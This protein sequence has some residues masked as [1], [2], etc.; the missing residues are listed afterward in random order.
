MSKYK[1]TFKMQII[2][3]N[4][5]AGPGDIWLKHE[6]ALPFPPTDNFGYTDGNW[7]I[8]NPRWLEEPFGVKL[9]Y[10]DDGRTLKVFLAQLGKEE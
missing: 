4:H 6:M 7:Y 5:S 3:G 10:Q 1:V 8:S 2:G 9:S